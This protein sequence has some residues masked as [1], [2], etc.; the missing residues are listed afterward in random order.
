MRVVEVAEVIKG[1]FAK[2]SLARGSSA[3]RTV[4]AA[5]QQKQAKQV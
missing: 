1:L 3:L 5:S 2:K 4:I